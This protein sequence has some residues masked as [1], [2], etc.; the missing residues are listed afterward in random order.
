MYAGAVKLPVKQAVKMHRGLK[1][2][3]IL[4]QSRGQE[5]TQSEIARHQKLSMYEYEDIVHG[6]RKQLS[7]DTPLKNGEDTTYLDLLEKQDAIPCDEQVIKQELSSKI[8]ALLM[9]LPECEKEI[10]RMRFGFDGEEKT[11]EEIGLKIGV[12]RERVR[13]IEKRAKEELKRK[14]N[15]K[16]SFE[17]LS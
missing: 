12:S 6:Y 2:S 9:N 16:T 1:I 4:A 11:L 13:Q 10:L 17:P 5:P 8:S 15:S 3:K 7:L 14:S